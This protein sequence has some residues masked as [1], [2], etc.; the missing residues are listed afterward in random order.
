MYTCS[1]IKYLGVLLDEHMTWGAQIQKVNASL[2][3]ANKLLSKARYYLPENLLLQLY[4]SQFYSKMVYGCQLWGENLN[5]HSQTSIL[6]RKA[7]RVIAFSGFKADTN[8]I[9]KELKMLKI[10]DLIRVNHMLFVHNVLNQKIP[11][12]FKNFISKN[13]QN[14]GYNTIKSIKSKYS[15]P[16][17]SVVVPPNNSK[18]YVTVHEQCALTWNNLLKGLTIENIKSK[19]NKDEFDPLWL[20]R[21]S[22]NSLKGLLKN[23]FIS[24]Y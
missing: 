1:E 8:P 19:T 16:M 10:T 15:L 17:G 3:R 9:F 6:Q 21:L 13:E 5:D 22:I 7:M 20:E 14:H 2:T 24:K 18:R 4:Y 23:Y 11:H 12:Y